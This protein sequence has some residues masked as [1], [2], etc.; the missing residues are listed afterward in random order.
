MSKQYANNPETLRHAISAWW[1]DEPLDDKTL[2]AMLGDIGQVRC[3]AGAY[4]CIGSRIRGESFLTRNLLDGINERLDELP[5]AEHRN[6]GDRGS[7][8]AFPSRAVRQR[9]VWQG[10]I[11]ASLFAAVTAV[12][13]TVSLSEDPAAE[14]VAPMQAEG[15]TENDRAVMASLNEQAMPEGVSPATVRPEQSTVGKAVPA[16]S[17]PAGAAQL[18]D[19]ATGQSSRGADP[20]VVTHYRT[21]APEFG[22]TGPEARAA[23]FGR[24]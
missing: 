21:A 7:V 20:Y 24:E 8:V 12:G 18:P 6:R 5:D 1:D 15:L 17:S 23:T 16:S 9:R 19:W 10:A 2:D 11:A 13:L 22:T 4:E 14:G 3:H